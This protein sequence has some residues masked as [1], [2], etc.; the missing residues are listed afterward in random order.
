MTK[1]TAYHIAIHIVIFDMFSRLNCIGRVWLYF[2]LILKITY[3]TRVPPRNICMNVCKR[4]D[5][6]KVILFITYGT[7][8][9]T[10][11]FCCVFIS[12]SLCTMCMYLTN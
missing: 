10:Y 3:I 2:P 4:M 1:I 5:Y 8:R 11:T 9:Q 6:Y 7:I 12:L